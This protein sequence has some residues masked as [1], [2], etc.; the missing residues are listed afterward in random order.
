MK[1][2]ENLKQLNQGSLRTINGGTQI[3]TFDNSDNYY[4]AEATG[5]FMWGFIRGLLRL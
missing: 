3:P 4:A 5:S 2:I 1:T